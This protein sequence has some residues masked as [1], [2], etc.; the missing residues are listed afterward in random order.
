MVALLGSR[1]PQHDVSR[2]PIDHLLAQV[3]G[4]V[5]RQVRVSA[6]RSFVRSYTRLSVEAAGATAS[7]GRQTLEPLET[8]PPVGVA[9]ARA[10]TRRFEAAERRG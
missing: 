9:T 6:T 10:S 8:F 2:A 7:A 4:D 5:E 3:P 1:E